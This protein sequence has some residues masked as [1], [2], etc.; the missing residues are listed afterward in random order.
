METAKGMYQNIMNKIT[1]PGQGQPQPTS[2]QGGIANV[3]GTG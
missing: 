1:I 3:Q 2:S